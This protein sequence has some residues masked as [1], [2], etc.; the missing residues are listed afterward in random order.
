[1]RARVRGR[2]L[3]SGGRP[4]FWLAVTLL[5]LATS[6]SDRSGA[7]QVSVPD[8]TGPAPAAVPPNRL[9][10]KWDWSRVNSFAPYLGQMSGG[11]TFFE[12]VWCEVQ[13]QRGA[14]LRWEA[15]DA[16]AAG[17]TKLGYTLAFKVRTGTCWA[18]DGRG[19][20]PRGDRG[21]TASA[22]P[23]DP[24]AHDAF[25][26]AAVARYGARGVHLWA[27][28]NEVNAANS[29]KGTP[30]EY[31][32]LARRTAA[33]IRAADP[34]A[35][36]ADFGLSSTG[37]GT[38]VAKDLLGQKG[39]EDDAVA[40]WNS[41]FAR[42]GRAAFPMVQTP[43]ELSRAL[44]D[45]LTERNLAMFEVARG[46]AADGVVDITQVHFYEAPGNVPA[47][48]ELFQRTFPATAR[49]EAWEVGRFDRPGPTAAEPDLDLQAGEALRS[50]VSLLVGGAQRVI[51]L[52]AA[53]NPEGR[54]PDEPR[55]G[56]MQPDGTVRPAGLALAALVAA[57][58]VDAQVTPLPATSRLEG[59]VFAPLAGPAVLV[60][61]ARDQ[62]VRLATEGVVVRLAPAAT[63]ADGLIDV[64]GSPVVLEV[65]AGTVAALA[66]GT[67]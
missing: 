15:S 40:A 62:A 29:W 51:W 27:I 30:K 47:L 59:A 64:G 41:W 24:A 65:T 42:R 31:D 32:R 18:T 46:L 66:L 50:V 12:L 57:T 56:L 14:D 3:V 16:V 25:V 22:S 52:P 23:A 61:W 11:T 20:D 13:P 67:A 26:S 2:E 5:V 37:W 60:A 39:R 33:T 48:A 4:R 6:C 9:G 63:V 36:V 55:A 28:E 44:D 43:A 35:M 45:P 1:M 34:G 8:V 10:V 38:A 58:A 54:N 53:V 49:M 19:S 7:G 17:S 21:K